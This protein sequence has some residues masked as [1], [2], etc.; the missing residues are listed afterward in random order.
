MV[1]GMSVSAQTVK[2]MKGDEVV[3]EY[4]SADYDKV[5]FEEEHSVLLPGNFSVATDKTVQFTRG[6][7]YWDGS[8]YRIEAEQ[9][10]CPTV[11]NENHVGHF[12]W[13]NDTDYK[14]GNASY[15]PYASVYVHGTRSTEDK[16]FCGE[17]NPLTVEGV[18]GLFA[19]NADEWY[20]LCLSRENAK[21]LI[22][23]GVTVGNTANCLVLAPDGFAE[24]LKS[25]YTLAEVH[26]L[27]LLCL[28]PAGS[29]TG[30]GFIEDEESTGRYWSSSPGW[31][32]YATEAY[33]LRF[34]SFHLNVNYY[35]RD[36]AHCLR[37]VRRTQD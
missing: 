19:L 28:V 37:L 30:T 21:N 17:D 23:Y 25:E 3:K 26:A 36:C 2:I 34:D 10:D 18:S 14:S 9:T 6:N 29:R 27:G 11:W 31:L 12:Y 22:K 8:D 13:T 15:M 35:E 7:L 32:S 5:V 33:F 16:F 4:K 24:T 1:C 20:Y